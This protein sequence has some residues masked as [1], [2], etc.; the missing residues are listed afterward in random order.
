MSDC[1]IWHCIGSVGIY[2][3]MDPFSQFQFGH[4]ASTV[5]WESYWQSSRCLGVGEFEEITKAHGEHEITTHHY[6][7]LVATRTKH[8][9]TQLTCHYSTGLHTRI[10]KMARLALHPNATYHVVNRQRMT[11]TTSEPLEK[12]K[13]QLAGEI[14][15]QEGKVK[16]IDLFLLS[17]MITIGADEMCIIEN[18]H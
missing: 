8:N 10:H 6:C 5:Q 12:G 3:C 13:E 4:L 11:L 14:N 2:K 9:C 18:T 15:Q 16:I 17:E 1:L 7:I